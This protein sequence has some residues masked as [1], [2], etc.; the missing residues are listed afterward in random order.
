MFC[1]QYREICHKHGWMTTDNG[2]TVFVCKENEEGDTYSFHANRENFLDEVKAASDLLSSDVQSYAEGVFQILHGERSM[3]KCL[4]AGKRF[5]N[6]LSTLYA[7]LRKAEST[8]T[9]WYKLFPCKPVYYRQVRAAYSEVLYVKETKMT[10]RPYAV[11]CIMANSEELNSLEFEML[12]VKYPSIKDERQ[13]LAYRMAMALF[14]MR[15]DKHVRTIYD[16]PF[17][18]Y[19]DAALCVYELTNTKNN[20]ED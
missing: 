11:C 1:A 17:F 14:H 20:E 4:N 13:P 7:E 12:A 2:S 16:I 8:V 10:D 18:S 3:E 15:S 9:Q 19:G 5:S 6:S